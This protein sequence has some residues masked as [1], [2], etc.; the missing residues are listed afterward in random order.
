[1][2]YN[3]NEMKQDSDMKESMNVKRKKLRRKKE[4][5]Q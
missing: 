4:P 3:K 5:L 2:K 1:M